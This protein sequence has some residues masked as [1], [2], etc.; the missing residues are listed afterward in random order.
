MS[1]PSVVRLTI[2]PI[3][4]LSTLILLA[5]A[6]M[7]SASPA[8]TGDS[9]TTRIMTWNIRYDNP[10][11]G[12]HAWPKRREDLLAFIRSQKPGILCI[13]EGLSPQVTFLKEGLENFD[14]RGV[15]RDDGKDKGEFSSIYF[16]TTRFRCAASGTFWLSPTPD[17]P[18]KGW[19]AALNRIASWAKLYD[20]R[21]SNLVY[22]FNTHFDHMGKI[23]RD[24]SAGLI[25]KKISEIA[26]DSPVLLA[27]DF[28]SVESDSPYKTLTSTQSQLPGLADAR[29]SSPIPDPGPSL[30]FTGFEGKESITNERIDFVFVSQTV[31]VTSHTTCVARSEAGYLSDHL[32]VIAEVRF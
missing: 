21:T 29:R 18:S 14:V 19:D 8:C 1:R 28:N 22:V 26:G 9:T 4:C 11:D 24:S 3:T 5:V 23:A 20:T 32:P 15:G 13:Q 2:A 27:G 16:D 30:T 10:D 25:R 31:V 12:I 17:Q 6:T 7:G